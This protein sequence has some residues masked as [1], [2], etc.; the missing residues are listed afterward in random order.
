MSCLLLETNP[1][2]DCRDLNPTRGLY[3]KLGTLDVYPTVNNGA[4]R[5][6]NMVGVSC[7][8]IYKSSGNIPSTFFPNGSTWLQDNQCNKNEH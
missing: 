4:I 6:F 2:R 1:K 8:R 7:N 5:N 3:A